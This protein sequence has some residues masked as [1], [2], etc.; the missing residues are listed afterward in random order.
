MSNV[1]F[2]PGIAVAQRF[3]NKS[4]LPLLSALH[5]APLA[6]LWYLTGAALSAGQAALI[7]ALVLLAA[8]GMA[9][10]YFQANLGWVLLFAVVR[11]LSEGDLTAPIDTH[12]GGH[13]GEVMRALQTVNR[14]LGEIVGQVRASSDSVSTAA[15]EIS[16]GN[17][18]L[19]QRTEQQATTLEETASSM[20]ELAATVRDNAANCQRANGLARDAERTAREG[21]H[22]VHA[23]VASMGTIESSSKRMAD[24]VGTI[25][26]IAFQTNILALNAAVEAAHAGAQG[27]GFAVVAAEV[28]ALAQRCT[29]AAKEVSGLIGES[30]AQITEGSRNADRA[31]HVIGGIVD[32]AQQTSSLIAEISTASAEQAS[33]VEEVNR[34]VT[35]LE[36]M[37]Q[38]NA[39]LVE[40]ATATALS[41]EDEASRLAGLVSR[42]RIA[43]DA[44]AARAP[45]AIDWVPA[46]SAR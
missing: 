36:G 11:R 24:I 12:L 38:Q 13:F 14:N 10:F 37:T 15:G 44:P 18:H 5:F 17:A 2:A 3:G 43:G 32:G 33:G 8:Y 20:E 42:F 26:Q 27:H 23:V 25:D 9:S 34:A 35:Q 41:F 40:Q 45:V 19:S 46:R 22:A 29:Q 6:V 4:K 30:I 1:F 39:A 7:A 28:R 31:G 16:S 21:A